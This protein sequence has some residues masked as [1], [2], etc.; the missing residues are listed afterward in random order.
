MLLVI[1]GLL[2][3]LLVAEIALRVVGYSSPYFY[4]TD[5]HR[6]IA[7]RAGVE[8]WYRREGRQYIKINSD[9]LRDHEHSRQKPADHLRIAVI[10]DSYAEAFQVPMENA[11]WA[12]MQERLQGCQALAGQKVEVINFG[13]SG[14]GTAQELIT[15]R[16]HVWDYSPD[17]IILTMTTNNDVTDNSRSLKKSDVPYFVYRDGNLVLD[18]SFQNSRTFRLRNSSLHR[19]FD[20]LRNRSRVVQAIEEASRAIRIYMTSKRGQKSNQRGAAQVESVRPS[21]EEVGIDNMI[22]RAPHDA[23]WEDAWRVTEG[24][25][26]LMS[27]EVRSRGAKF[28]V[29]TLSN[30]IQ[31]YPNAAAR[32]D[33]MRRLDITD[34]LYPDLR[35]K[36]FCERESIPVLALAPALQAYAEQNNIFL[37]GFDDNLGNGH[38]NPSGHRLAGEMIAQKLCEAVTN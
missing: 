34:L 13:V 10:G 4:T 31:V 20:Q 5:Q 16:R 32:Q 19:L 38:W 8:G 27:D 37:H 30:G 12:V 29:V 18:D 24:L 3:G 7:L 26:K 14:Y 35:I 17:I 33:F 22:Y 11:F 21:Y 28:M 6:G 1:G 23:V 36:N 2:A 9:G 15:L 25:V